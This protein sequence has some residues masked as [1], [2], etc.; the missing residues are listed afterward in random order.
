MAPNTTPTKRAKIVTMK[1][2]GSTNDEI[3]AALVGRH[4]LSNKQIGRIYKKYKDKENYYDFGKKSGRPHKLSARDARAALRHLGNRDAHDAT[5][6]QKV[7]FPEVH[8]KTVKR[9]LRENGLEA[10]PRAS[11]PCI[12]NVNL[13]K[14]M[15]FAEKYLDWT[16]EMFEG[17]TFCDES[18]FRKIGSD[19]M[20][21][22]WRRRGERLDPRFTKKKVKHGG[23]K[24]TVWGMITAHGVGRIVRIEGNLT[25]VLY[26]EILEDDAL[27]TFSDLNLN[28][29]KFIFQQ[30]NDP[31]HTAKIVTSWF[32]ENRI[33][34]LPWPPSSPDIN[35]IENLWDY[36]DRLVRARD[37]LPRTEE[38]LWVALQEEWVNIPLDYIKKLYASLPD[39]IRAV[40]DAKGGNTRY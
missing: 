39:R 18:I 28:P 33:R 19:G 17:I 26:R 22:C 36:L 3:R 7:Y 16:A 30:D 1:K 25:A 29:R 31:K 12:T 8:V 21:W 14:R 35:I 23:G 6:L 2:A 24:V 5:D 27:G 11:V 10:H 40:Y 4:D 32:T 20:E 9:M 34:Q 15:N 13:P 38:D 37:P